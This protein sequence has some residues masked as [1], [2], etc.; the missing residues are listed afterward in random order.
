MGVSPVRNRASDTQRKMLL[1][2][3]AHGRDAHAT[4][5]RATLMTSVER[6]QRDIETIAGFTQT[7]G[8]GATRP[9]FSPAWVAARDYVIRELEACGCRARIDAGNHLSLLHRL[10]AFDV[11]GSDAPG[12]VGSDLGLSIGEKAAGQGEVARHLF[13][14]DRRQLHLDRGGG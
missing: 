8:Q 2:S 12:D 5:L 6:I 1:R 10:S 13:V 14:L 4:F 7:P 11:G 9:T 3:I